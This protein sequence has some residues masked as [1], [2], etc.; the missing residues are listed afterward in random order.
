MRL[1]CM[2]IPVAIL[3]SHCRPPDG[4]IANATRCNGRVAEI[5]NSQG[6]WDSFMDCDEVEA[7]SGGSWACEE[8]GHLCLPAQPQDGGAG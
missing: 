2:F 6:R 5:C 7:Q 3:L 1:L 4:C 8:P